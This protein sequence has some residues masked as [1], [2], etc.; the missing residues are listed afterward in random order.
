MKLLL[1]LH[2]QAKSPALF[3]KYLSTHT[4]NVAFMC[5]Q[6]CYKKGI[7]VYSNMIREKSKSLYDKAKGR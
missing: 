5:V 3:V 4:E 6:G 7:P 1:Q 2:Q